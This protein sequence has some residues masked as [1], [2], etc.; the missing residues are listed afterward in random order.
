MRGLSLALTLALALALAVPAYAKERA[1]K[2]SVAAAFERA[3]YHYTVPEKIRV[4]STL[5]SGVD[6]SWSL[7]TGS[8]GK[9]GL[10]AA[11][12]RRTAAG[13]H[14]V[15]IFRTRTFDPGRRPPCDIRPAFS[16][17]AC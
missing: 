5:R 9:R 15:E 17:P 8:Y 1:P 10:W 4:T 13:R 6:R 7:V 12:V 3:V 11:W 2:A 16:E 14:R